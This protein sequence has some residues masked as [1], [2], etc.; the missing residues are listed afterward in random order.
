M[1][2]N[3][4]QLALLKGAHGLLDALVSEVNLSEATELVDAYNLIDYLVALYD[5]TDKDNEDSQ[6]IVD[7]TY[8]VFGNTVEVVDGVAFDLD[9]N[10]EMPIELVEEIGEYIGDLD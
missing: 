2:L 5:V 6:S 1:E 7:G 9:A 3:N 8:I 4:S 10:E